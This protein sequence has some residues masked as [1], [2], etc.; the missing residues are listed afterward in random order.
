MKST[1]LL[2]ATLVA[3]SD[4]L[5]EIFPTRLYHKASNV[6]ARYVKGTQLPVAP[7]TLNVVTSQGCFKSSGNLVYDSTPDW[8]TIGSCGNE[9]CFA[10]GYAVGATTGGNQCWCGNEYP[11]KADL[12]DDKNCDVGCTGY[13][14]Q[15]CELCWACRIPAAEQQLTWLI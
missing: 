15:A 13:G 5:P 2:V 8:N 10:K 4:A 14:D 3:A 7:A 1:V 11:A 12:V 6:V 9:I